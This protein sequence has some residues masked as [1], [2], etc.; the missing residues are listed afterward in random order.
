MTPSTVGPPPAAMD[1]RVRSPASF[2]SS[3]NK[4]RTGAVA[5]RYDLVNTD[6]SEKPNTMYVRIYGINGPFSWDH[7]NLGS[8]PSGDATLLHIEEITGSFD[9]TTFETPAL[10]V[11]DG[12]DYYVL[13]F[14]A[15]D[16]TTAEGDFMAIDN[17]LWS[18]AAP[19][20]VFYDVTF[21]AG[22][23]GSLTGDPTK[24]SS[25]AAAPPPSPPCPPRA[26]N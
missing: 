8:N 5:F 14:Y 7:W 13:R 19:P 4:T 12:Y 24:L 15:S 6:G 17:L 21:A 9:W 25:A 11:G 20:P 23:N 2:T 18:T 26:T 16:V 3:D 10:P 1:G 22:A